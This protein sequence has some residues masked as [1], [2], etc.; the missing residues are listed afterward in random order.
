MKKITFKP[1]A[2]ILAI[3]SAIKS[4][5]TINQVEKDF[6]I[7]A[8]F[9]ISEGSDPS[10]ALKIRSKQ[11]VGKGIKKRNTSKVSTTINISDRLFRI[12]HIAYMLNVGVSLSEK[13][14]KFL[15]D[16]LANIAY[17]ENPIDSFD[18]RA[19]QGE[20]KG[21]KAVHSADRRGQV[22]DFVDNLRKN[23]S[24]TLDKAC[25]EAEKIFDLSFDTIKK[26]V[27]MNK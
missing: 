24:L 19:K 2:R 21:A 14:N 17:G 11:G 4:R 12:N 5:E 3:S 10:G 20:R 6:L 25:G 18:I 22:I 9:K 27:V 7:E 13:E 1:L 15:S 8:L 16:A 26:Y 23:R